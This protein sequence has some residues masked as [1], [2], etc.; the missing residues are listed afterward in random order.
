MLERDAASR[1][2]G[3]LSW[4]L[5]L[6]PPL[7]GRRHSPG[8]ARDGRRPGAPLRRL[9]GRP[10]RA[11]EALPRR[12]P[13]PPGDRRHVPPPPPPRTTLPVPLYGGAPRPAWTGTLVARLRRRLLHRP[14]PRPGLHLCAERTPRPA[15]PTGRT[16]LVGRPGGTGGRPRRRGARWPRSAVRRTEG[17]PL[18]WPPA[19]AR[20]GQR[21]PRQPE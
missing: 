19:L 1:R 7:A 5:V 21:Q 2:V 3:R 8:H 9:P 20:L 4:D 11:G 16:F 17:H 10:E 14:G 18:L 15:S 6:F 12:R 13:L